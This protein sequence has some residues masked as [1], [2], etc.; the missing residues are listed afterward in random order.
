MAEIIPLES[1]RRQATA[2]AAPRPDKPAAIVIFPGVRYEKPR[3][4]GSASPASPR[5]RPPKAN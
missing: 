2:A 3:D 4:G 1:R 5:H